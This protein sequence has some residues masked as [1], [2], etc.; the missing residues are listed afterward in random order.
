M[1]IAKK[2]TVEAANDRA[3]R[4]GRVFI[5]VTCLFYFLM[6]NVTLECTSIFFRDGLLD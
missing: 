3:I 4:P 5:I 2:Q 6:P 1:E